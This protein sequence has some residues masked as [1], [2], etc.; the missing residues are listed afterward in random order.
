MYSCL[1]AV[2]LIGIWK[3]DEIQDQATT[4]FGFADARVVVLVGTS[5]TKRFVYTHTTFKNNI[6]CI[7][8]KIFV[9]VFARNVSN[10]ILQTITSFV[11]SSSVSVFLS[12]PLCLLDSVCYK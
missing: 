6:Q 2:K 10:S 7:T 1:V 12:T 11:F 3:R 9:S 8:R 4:H 5:F